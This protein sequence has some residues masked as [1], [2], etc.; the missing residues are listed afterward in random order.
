MELDPGEVQIVKG[1]ALTVT[2]KRIVYDQGEIAVANVSAPQVE[3]IEMKVSAGNTV[4]AIGAVLVLGGMLV[5]YPLLW[6]VGGLMCACSPLAKVKRRGLAVT[7]E[8][9]G[10]RKTIYTTARQEEAKLAY[11]AI[12]EALRRSAA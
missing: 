5:Q 10:T 3:E 4:V 12:E 9:A 8:T 2:D 7:V 6:I 11:A 1:A